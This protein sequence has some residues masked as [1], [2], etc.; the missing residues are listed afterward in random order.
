MFGGLSTQFDA[1][2]RG[3]TIHY[4]SSKYKAAAMGPQWLTYE[5]LGAQEQSLLYISDGV[6]IWDERRRITG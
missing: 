6:I 4:L 3:T 5:V 2:K 1:T